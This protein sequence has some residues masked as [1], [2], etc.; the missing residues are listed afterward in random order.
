M[1]DIRTKTF[2]IPAGASASNGINMEH[3]SLIGLLVPV[4]TGIGTRLYNVLDFDDHSMAG[5][6]ATVT[7]NAA[8]TVLT[9]G[10]EWDAETSETVTA[11]NL[12]AAINAAAIGVSATH[13]AGVVTLIPGE[14]VTA[15][16]V[17]TS[18]HAEGMTVTQGADAVTTKLEI[19]HSADLDSVAD[20]DATWKPV[21]DKSTNKLRAAVVFQTP[22]LSHLS[23]G[24]DGLRI[25]RIRLVAAKDDGTAVVQLAARTISPKFFEVK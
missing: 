11:H 5:C 23:P 13:V 17:A 22:R 6:T 25:G 4:L 19:Q 15:L 24:T 10:V 9:E 16:V 12:A 14:D 1:T 8:P 20:G 18:A 3:L 7:V 21:Y 2:V